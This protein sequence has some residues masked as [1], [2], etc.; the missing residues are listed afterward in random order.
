MAESLLHMELVRKIASYV[1]TITPFYMSS[2]MDADL[3]E[4][5]NRTQRVIKGYYPDVC[6]RDNDIIVI[7]E[8][9]TD[10]DI[11]NE[12]TEGQL[13]AYIEEV[14]N[15]GLQRHIIYSVPFV[16]FIQV[17]NMLKRLKEARHIDDITFHVLDNFNRVVLL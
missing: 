12:H 15:Y 14:R 13:L 1:E 6:Y 16:V 10:K 4:Y 17:K 11:L 7:G 5:E 3:P 9:K 2:L 8:A